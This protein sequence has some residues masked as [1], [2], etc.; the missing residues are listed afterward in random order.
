MLHNLWLMRP[1]G[2]STVCFDNDPFH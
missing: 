1:M 2:L